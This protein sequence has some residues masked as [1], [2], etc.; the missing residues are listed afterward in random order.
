MN[1]S[2]RLIIILIL[3]LVIVIVLAFVLSIYFTKKALRDVIRSFREKNALNPETAKFAQE[4]GIHP[5]RFI[6][7]KALRDY[8]PSALLLL[9]QQN[10][11]HQLDDGRLYLAES[12]LL[13]S[14]LEKRIYDNYSR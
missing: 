5:P 12:N 11:V 13:G 10:I 1:E 9:Q 4:L 2:T 14:E 7:F 6:Q 8:K 3:I